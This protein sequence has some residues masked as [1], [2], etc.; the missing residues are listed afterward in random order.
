MSEPVVQVNFR[1]PASLKTA[2]EEE[3][4]RANRSLTAEIVQRLDDS[5][6][7]RFENVDSE[8]RDTAYRLERLEKGLTRVLQNIGEMRE[9]ARFVQS[10]PH[11]YNPERYARRVALEDFH[12][13]GEYRNPYEPLTPEH[14]SY[15]TTFLWSATRALG[16][17]AV[18]SDPKY[19]E[20]LEPLPKFLR[21]D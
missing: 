10:N 18:L 21:A 8:H 16:K 7:R 15:R 19:A 5:L 12:E 4:Q 3:A 20:I 1:M 6:S 11:R 13:R 17:E 9:R 14:G 2:L